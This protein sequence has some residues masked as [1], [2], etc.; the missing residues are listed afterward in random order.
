MSKCYQ[1]KII[2]ETK[3]FY[4]NNNK[5]YKICLQCRSWLYCEHNKEKRKC[6]KCKGSQICEHNKNKYRCKICSEK[7]GIRCIHNKEKYDC[8]DCKGNGICKH[9]KRK[10]NCIE[11][12]G[13]QVCKHNKQKSDCVECKGSQICVHG[14]RKQIC[15][16][17][18]GSQICVHGKRKQV[19]KICEPYKHLISLQRRRINYI[20]KTSNQIKS[21]KTIEYLGCSPEFLYNYITS[22]LTKEMRISG[23][24]I[25]HI[26]PISKFDL[27]EKEQL[28]KCCHWSNLQP[29]L[30]KDNRY[31]SNKW[32]DK[33]EK[34]WEK[35]I[36]GCR[37]TTK[38]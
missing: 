19:C 25:D 17:C 6:S 22:M 21:K 18:K 36:H 31:K 1:C 11:C 12:K 7:K 28:E 13:S 20:L 34:L 5:Y 30:L 10:R 38:I 15:V 23:Y 2:K 9:G 35:L 32:T 4:Y 27:S 37:Q 16:D 3:E 14:K 8:I 26:K 29:L 33:D 24:E